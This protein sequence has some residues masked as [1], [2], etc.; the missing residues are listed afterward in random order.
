MKNKLPICPFLFAYRCQNPHE[1]VDSMDGLIPGSL[2]RILQNVQWKVVM[3][4]QIERL[5]DQSVCFAASGKHT[6]MHY[7]SDEREE[8]K[9]PFG[10]FA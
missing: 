6:A 1:E 4:E 5:P 3:D 8:R 2:L 10:S 7:L 9:M